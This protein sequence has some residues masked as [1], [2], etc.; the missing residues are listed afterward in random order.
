MRAFPYIVANYVFFHILGM[1]IALIT[2]DFA[3]IRPT[4]YVVKG[5]MHTF[6]YIAANYVF[7]HILGMLIALIIDD[8]TQ[9]RPTNFM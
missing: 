4:N 6:P 2:D 3:Q 7:F 5:L 9:I 8:F 1:L